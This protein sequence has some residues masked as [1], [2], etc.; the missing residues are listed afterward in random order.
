[1]SA[2]HMTLGEI[3]S[4]TGGVIQT[5]PFGSQLHAHDYQPIGTPVVM[6]T[7]LGDN[8]IREEGIVRVGAEDVKRL[9]RHKLRK[10]DIVFSRRGDVGRRSIVRPENEGWLCGTGCLAVKFGPKQASVNP[11]FISL[12]VGHASVQSWLIDNAVGGTMLNLNTGILSSLPLFLPP[13]SEQDAATEVLEDIFAQENQIRRLIEKKRDIKQGVIQELL[14][15][16]TRLPGFSRPWSTIR[17]GDH[18]SYIKSVALSR[19][20]LN[21]SS[22]LRYLH[23]GDIHT[24]TASVLNAAQEEMP[25]ASR[26]LTRN[27]AL[28]KVGDLVF[29]DASEDPEGVGKSVEVIGVPPE[30]VIP[31]LHTIS[32]RFDKR[33]LADGFKGYLQFIPSFRTQLLSLAAGTKV[34]ATTRA[35]ISSIELSL[36]D[37]EE[38]AAMANLLQDVDSEIAAL[39]RRLDS[40]RA[41]KQGVMQELLT[42]RTRLTEVAP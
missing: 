12:L 5:G 21:S 37:V 38:Q 42:G 9:S 2:S 30:G 28:L 7:N 14:T 13:R 17:L 3:V 20:Q 15:G 16:Q 8:A 26:A 19:A 6:P 1:M 36:P 4:Q 25:R 33:V 32:A 31:G 10:N 24:R 41:I 18:V 34:L 35:F 27:A 22:P 39:E 11:R 40:A 29:A 23:Y